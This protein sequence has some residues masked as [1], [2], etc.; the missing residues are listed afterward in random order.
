M[1]S[2]RPTSR[3]CPWRPTAITEP[4]RFL[5]IVLQDAESP[6]TIWNN[7]GQLLSHG[8]STYEIPTMG[9][10][11]QDFRLALLPNAAQEGTV[12]GSKAV[13]GH[14]SLAISMREAI[15]DTI[16]STGLKGEISLSSPA[17]CEAIYR[18]AHLM[19]ASAD[20]TERWLRGQASSQWALCI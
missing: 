8:T 2:K 10:M 3:G 15:R 17:T 7:K 18:A 5:M 20:S 12:R 4:P 9:D 6:F 1:S 13:G 19:P 14:R 16:A 11:P